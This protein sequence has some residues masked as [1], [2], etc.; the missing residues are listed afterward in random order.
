[1]DAGSRLRF[2]SHQDHLPSC[3]HC[4]LC[5]SADI[6]NPLNSTPCQGR[7]LDHVEVFVISR[8]DWEAPGRIGTQDTWQWV[9]REPIGLLSTWEEHPRAGTSRGARVWFPIP[10]HPREVLWLLHPCLEP[11]SLSMWYPN[12]NSPLMLRFTQ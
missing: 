2:T 9:A 10:I 11:R 4:S 12:S 8:M 6:R 1:M 5:V 7:P 3:R